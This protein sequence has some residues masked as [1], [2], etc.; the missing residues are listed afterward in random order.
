[1]QTV[2]RGEEIFLSE[3]CT[4][5]HN[6]KGKGGELAPDLTAV[7]QRRSTVWIMTQIKNPRSHNPDSRMPEFRHLSIIERFAI[8]RYLEG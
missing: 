6:F 8:A 3:G 2:S 5:C 1:M 7:G 4:N